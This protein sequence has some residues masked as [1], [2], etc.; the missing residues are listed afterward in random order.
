[1]TRVLDLVPGMQFEVPAFP[2]DIGG[3]LSTFVGQTD[4][5]LYT[6]LRLVIWRMPAGHMV[7]DWSHDALD[8]RQDVG[9]PRPSTADERTENLRGALLGGS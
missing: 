4:H 7:G 8:A 1:M 5:P 3:G 2:G 6:G 9:E